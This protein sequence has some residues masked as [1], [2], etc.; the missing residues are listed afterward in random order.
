MQKPNLL[1]SSLKCLSCS[2]IQE[3]VIKSTISRIHKEPISLILDSTSSYILSTF[4]TM[5]D[6]LSQGV[7][8][9]ENLAT[10]R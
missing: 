4:L 8:S 1:Q 10:K 2:R 9:I 7:F 3:D 6:L 5:T